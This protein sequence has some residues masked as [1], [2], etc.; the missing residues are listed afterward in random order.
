[1][2]THTDEEMKGEYQNMDIGDYLIAANAEFRN[3]DKI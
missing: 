1:L 2:A 3:P